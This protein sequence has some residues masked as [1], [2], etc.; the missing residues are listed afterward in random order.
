MSKK[1][2]IKK[3]FNTARY[4]ISFLFVAFYLTIAFLFLFTN[5]WGDLIPDKRGLIGLILLVFAALRFY[6]AFARYRGKKVKLNN[7][8]KTK[9]NVSME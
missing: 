7:S 6:V 1:I 4:G 3:G 9:E 8:I 5:T 2:K